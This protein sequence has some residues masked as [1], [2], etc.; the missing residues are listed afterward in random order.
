MSDIEN[1]ERDAAAERQ[2]LAASLDALSASVNRGNVKTHAA[3]LM[4]QYG[5]DLGRQT[6]GVAKQNPAAFALVG[7]GLALM[8]SGAGSRPDVAPAAKPTPQ[9][10]DALDGFDERIAAADAK[11]AKENSPS[12]ATLEQRLNDG[13]DALPASARKRVIRARKAALAAQ[14]QVEHSAKKAADKSKTFLQKQPLAAGAIAVGMGALIGAFL[15]STRREDDLL[16]EHRDTVMAAAR[17]TLNEELEK[18]Q[19]AARTSMTR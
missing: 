9:P 11:M 2:T 12:A 14:K 4:D 17:A 13:L 19:S 10:N 15:P 18:V 3:A 8:L 6:W 5:G 7:A 16:G 1:L